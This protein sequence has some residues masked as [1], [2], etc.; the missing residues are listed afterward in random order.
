MT[1][2]TAIIKGA[3][4]VAALAAQT[5]GP[6]GRGVIISR[7]PRQPLVTKDGLETAA[8]IFF[9][10]PAQNMGAAYCREAAAKTKETVGDGSTVTLI[11]LGELLRRGR[12]SI[13]AGVHPGRLRPALEE[14]LAL[15]VSHLSEQRRAP[16]EAALLAVASLA[17]KDPDLGKLTMQALTGLGGGERLTVRPSIRGED[18]IE[19]TRPE[20]EEN[21][22]ITVFVGA[23][24]EAETKLRATLTQDAL[25]AARAA[26]TGGVIPGAGAALARAAQILPRAGGR[27]ETRAAALIWA[28]ALTAPLARLGT[29][30]GLE[31]GRLVSA[32]T[33]E[34]GDMVYDFVNACYAEADAA[35]IYD[36]LP[37]LLAA[38]R[39]ACGIAGLILTVAGE[40]KGGGRGSGAGGG[41]SAG[42]YTAILRGGPALTAL[43][44]G[45]ETLAIAAGVT[46]GP[47]GGQVYVA[48]ERGFP[49][50]TRDGASITRVV[51]LTEEFSDLGCAL[52]RE[53]AART[54]D[55]AGDG[56]TAAVILTA[57]LLKRA[58]PLRA[59]GLSAPALARALTQGLRHTEKY[60][61]ALTAPATAGD[62]R[63]T[64][65]LA[66]G[67]EA[68]ELAAAAF[69]LVG[70]DGVITVENSPATHS[71]TE[72]IPG[73]SFPRGYISPRMVTNPAENLA[74]LP[75]PLIFLTD[76]RIAYAQEIETVLAAAVKKERPLLIV[77]ADIAAD[78][79]T[80][81][82]S[83]HKR[84]GL[85]VTV[86]L[87]PA[88][89]ERRREEL[90]DIAVITGGRALIAGDETDW[91]QVR[92]NWL[93]E[94]DL[95]KVGA[96]RTDIIGGGG[97]QAAIRARGEE[98]QAL[99]ARRLPG[100]TKDKLEAR[101]GWFQGGAARIKVGGVTQPE[102]L[103]RT[104]RV[105]KAVR[106]A[107]CAW[108]TGL[109][110]GG[111]LALL[112]AAEALERDLAAGLAA[113]AGDETARAALRAY[114]LALRAPLARLAAN[115]GA[116]GE[117][118]L[119]KLAAS[120]PEVGFNAQTGQLEDLR[121][122]GII[123]AA[124]VVGAALAAA[125]SASALMLSAGGLV[126]PEK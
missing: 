106:A 13:Q 95:A 50:F 83:A 1:V 27:E 108:K 40:T 105:R 4:E 126:A 125:V 76:R 117:A 28:A 92:E 23:A 79:L 62:L 99:A 26:A 33:A 91:G 31:G 121:A 66:G 44:R 45:A 22:V 24:T 82:L 61:A 96:K 73:I 47:R 52:A 110:P 120:P 2:R 36:P 90:A 34:K 122:A 18:Y 3:E 21:D 35:R 57:A 70:P 114:A 10:D 20:G 113:A 60:L 98:L 9:R 16:D 74:V 11:L 77:A 94:A 100:W 69:A 64:A 97:D 42:N 116:S 32:L 49:R 109:L 102:A 37:V 112:R 51:R 15:I 58:L 67:D 12:I 30:A 48:P 46:L 43:H 6:F 80:L 41:E 107:Q 5:L 19:R 88:A 72:K 17:A 104:E 29:N 78:L 124:G 63:K 119:A 56:A 93:G 39:N 55:L 8:H 14:T 81:F 115:T 65:A 25:S 54:E 118:V 68:G 59:A 85:L 84:G 123:D 111:G 89:G 87:A 7:Y 71:V 101:L 75:N 103:E 38:L 86:V 53:A